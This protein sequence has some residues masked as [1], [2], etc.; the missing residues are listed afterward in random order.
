ML[1]ARNNFSPVNVARTTKK[2]GHGVYFLLSVGVLNKYIYCMFEWVCYIRHDFKVLSG[3]E[4]LLVFI[5]NPRK[6]A[7]FLR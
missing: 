4:W 3:F 7:I 6:I 1:V 5:L 2:V